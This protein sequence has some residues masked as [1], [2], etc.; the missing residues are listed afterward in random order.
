MHEIEILLADDDERYLASLSEFIGAEDDLRVVS[1]VGG[2]AEA[3]EAYI[4]EKPDVVVVDAVMPHID[5]IEAMR[6]ILER[7]PAAKV[8]VL[9]A[10]VSPDLERR[11]LSSGA[12]AFVSKQY[13]A[14]D[15]I[16]VVRRSAE[17]GGDIGH[18]PT[19]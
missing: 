3:V 1:A 6:R 14:H 19:H 17:G 9:T 11:A 10:H 2:G 8:V 13:A 12:A 16:N 4:A 15:L 5:G 7:N 18:A